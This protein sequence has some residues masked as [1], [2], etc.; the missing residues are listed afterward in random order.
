MMRALRA[1]LLTVYD[2]LVVYLGVT[3][4]GVLCLA[5]TPVALLVL[6][7]LA[8]QRG[9]ALGRYAIM[10]AFRFYL[11][12][13]SL[14]RRFSFDLEALDA[15]RNETSLII[16]PNH[17]SLLD[18]VMVISRLPNVAC[19]LKVELMNNLFLGAGARLARY[20][21]NKPARR[22][23][24]EA[25]A[26]FDSGSHL[27]LFPEGSRTAGPGLALKG[28]IALIAQ[29]AQVPVQTVVIESTNPA[30]LGKGW[31]LFRKPPLPIH[32]RLR[33][34]RRFPAPQNAQR[35]MSELEHYFRDELLPPAHAPAAGF[36]PTPS[37]LSSEHE[38]AGR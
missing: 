31:P 5:W 22:M 14:S 12:S 8:E 18:A 34:G 9:R 2:Y 11:A 36:A 30:Y 24:R 15:L 28:S 37:D 10:R 16:A 21:C 26:D 17:P 29:H 38:A 13:L 23:V 1:A 19:V 3:W 20:I 33:L 6:P 27:L 7:L 32:Y 25:I 35:F 4:L